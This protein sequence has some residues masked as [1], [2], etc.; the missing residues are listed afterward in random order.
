VGSAP[1]YPRSAL[2][3]VTFLAR[4]HLLKGDLDQAVAATRIG[5]GLRGQVQSPRGRGYLSSL[6]S[7][8]ARRTRSP[9][10]RDLLDEFDEASSAV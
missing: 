10:V 8:M 4:A 3:H 1:A 5:L 2:L 6:R 7:A 9:L